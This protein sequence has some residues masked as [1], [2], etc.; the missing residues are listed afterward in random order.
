ASTVVRRKFH[1]SLNSFGNVA[2]TGFVGAVI[3]GVLAARRP[4]VRALNEVPGLFAACIGVALLALLGTFLNDSGVIIAEMALLV[5][6][7]AAVAAGLD[8]VGVAGRT[9]GKDPERMVGEL[10]GSR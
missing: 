8:V 7:L 6:V 1:A 10:R 9:V 2:V 4:I 5:T 3:V